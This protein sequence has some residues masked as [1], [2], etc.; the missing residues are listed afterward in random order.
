VANNNLA[1]LPSG[2]EQ[3]PLLREIVIENN[4]IP[5][6]PHDMGASGSLQAVRANNTQLQSI[7]ES[8][9]RCKTVHAIEIDG[10][11]IGAGRY[12]ELPGYSEVSITCDSDSFSH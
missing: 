6:L 11:P 5:Q 10:T 8:L 1:A 2:F 12:D 7:P 3:M 9:L 4:P